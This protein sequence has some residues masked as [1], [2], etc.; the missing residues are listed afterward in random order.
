M[1]LNHTEVQ[2]TSKLLISQVTIR[3]LLQLAES[4]LHILV[5]LA[6]TCPYCLLTFSVMILYNKKGSLS[7]IIKY[8]PRS[9][10]AL[11]SHSNI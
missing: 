3:S 6:E 1:C 11:S 7:K 10:N 2:E 8:L 9:S 4:F 5:Q